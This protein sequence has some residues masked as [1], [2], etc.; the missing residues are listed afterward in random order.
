MLKEQLLDEYE[1]NELLL[2]DKLYIND[3]HI[4]K[5]ELLDLL[6]ISEKK[7]KKTVESVNERLERYVSAP[8]IEYIK[9]NRTYLLTK[10]GCMNISRLGSQY[11]ATSINFLILRAYLEK[12][13][14]Q[15][16]LLMDSL[17]LSRSDLYR[18]VKKINTVIQ[19]FNL[20]IK[21]NKINGTELQIRY[22]EQLFYQNVFPEKYLD[23][24]SMTT[25]RFEP[26]FNELNRYFVVDLNTVQKDKF[27]LWLKNMFKNMKI[28]RGT[29]D[30]PILVQQ[31]LKDN[32]HFDDFSE[33]LVKFFLCFSIK[34]REIDLISTYLFV[35]SFFIIPFDS[36]KSLEIINFSLQKKD[37]IG[38]TI[39]WMEKK[40]EQFVGTA[41]ANDVYSSFYLY[42]MFNCHCQAVFFSGYLFYIDT[43]L[44]SFY[45]SYN[46]NEKIIRKWVDEL[47]EVSI[48]K[49]TFLSRNKKFMI[50]KYLMYIYREKSIVYSPVQVGVSLFTDPLMET[51][52]IERLQKELSKNHRANVERYQEKSIYDLVVVNIPNRLKKS[53][54]KSEFVI[55]GIG[56]AKDKREISKRISVI[57]RKKF[58]NNRY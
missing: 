27:T 48:F 38:K 39:S 5:K 46:Y 52:F 29:L 2:L 50:Y 51:I 16:E 24:K 30:I 19:E 18:R 47:C 53:N 9:T 32:P 36:K 31:Y 11:A 45:E 15:A 12:E 37:I 4:E 56:T 49:Q 3:G 23:E 44:I 54:F 22:F 14:V 58:L 34:L 55:S 7:L 17:M 20:K 6:N 13:S 41:V 21:N 28:T 43:P 35:V 10:E 40:F 42:Y 25:Y 8:M 33:I 57:Q 1:K 26:L